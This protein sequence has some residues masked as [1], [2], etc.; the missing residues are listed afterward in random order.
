[1]LGYVHV[2]LT[3]CHLPREEGDREQEEER[4]RE[5]ESSWTR[6]GPVLTSVRRPWVAQPHVH[7]HATQVTDTREVNTGNAT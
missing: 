6:H 4:E 5:T 7:A 3:E 1:M 2:Q